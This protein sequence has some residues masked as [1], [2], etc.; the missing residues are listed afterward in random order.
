MSIARKTA[1]NLATTD[2]DADVVHVLHEKIVGLKAEISRNVLD[3]GGAL[4]EMRD[5]E[6]YRALGYSTFEDYLVS[7]EVAMHRTTAYS[8]MR[9]Y[10]RFRQVALEAIELDWRKLDILTQIIKDGDAPERILPLI[11]EARG[12]PRDELRERVRVGK[13]QR[14]IAPPAVAGATPQPVA[15]PSAQADPWTEP[16]A[17]PD[18]GLYSRP[19]P[20]A[21]EWPREQAA[22]YYDAAPI[23]AESEQALATIERGRLPVP[24]TPFAPRHTERDEAAAE[25]RA[26]GLAAITKNDPDLTTMKVRA[27][28]SSLQAD[29]H[30]RLLRLNVP[31]IK[32]CLTEGERV[33]ADTTMRR[34]RRLVDEW[35]APEQRGPRLV[36]GGGER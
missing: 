15:P 36:A 21:T 35:D 14:L 12:I 8:F 32:R 18:A 1:L 4:A 17:D 3:L 11:E 9:I 19:D 16:D 10:Q 25:R 5:H 13:Q 20:P 2:A 27:D 22:T 23:V 34:L 6:M 29:I 30:T 31:D 7:A 26:R 24:P 33:V 28:F